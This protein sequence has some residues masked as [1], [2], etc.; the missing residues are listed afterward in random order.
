MQGR[1]QEGFKINKVAM[2]IAGSNLRGNMAL[3]GVQNRVKV[4]DDI[5]LYHQEMLGVVWAT[6]KCRL[7][8]TSLRHFALTTHHR[9]LVP[10]LNHHSL[11]AV[12]IPDSNA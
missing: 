8:L 2:T 12:E 11:D 4:V 1:I 10:I 7:Y 6:S 9:P 5:L 3:Q